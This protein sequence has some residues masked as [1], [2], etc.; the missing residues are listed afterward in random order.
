MLDGETKKLGH[1]ISIAS[2]LRESEL[3]ELI[4]RFYEFIINSIF[5]NIK[6]FTQVNLKRLVTASDPET[7]FSQNVLHH[8]LHL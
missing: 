4:H 2:A 6:Y 7:I 3:K 8:A 5:N 1:P